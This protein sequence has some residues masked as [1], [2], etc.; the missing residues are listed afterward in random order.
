[1]FAHAA[2]DDFWQERLHYLLYYDEAFDDAEEFFTETEQKRIIRAIA[3]IKVIDPAVGS[4][5]F[6]MGILHKLTLA[7]RRLDADNH[8]WEDLQKELAGQRATAAFDTA[9]QQVRDEELREI[10]DTFQK[11]R[12]SDF[13]RKLY[14][15]QNSIFGVDI[16]PIACQIAKLRF[17]ISLAIEQEPDDTAT[18]YGIKPLPNLET[19]FVAANTLL[20]LGG[21]NRELISARTGELQRRLN[22]NRERHFHATTRRQKLDCREKDQELRDDLAAQLK[23]DGLPAAAANKVARWDPYDQNDKADW[24]DAEYM[25]GLTAGFDVVI[26]NPPY[27]ESRNSLLSGE[28]KDAYGNQVT[29]DWGEG[30]PRGSDLLIYFYAR[31]A[32]LV[33]DSGYGCFITQNAWLDTNYGHKFQKFSIGKF[34]F[35][36]IVDTSAKFFSDIS[37]QNINAVITI[38][39][40]RKLREIEYGIADEDMKLTSRRSIVARQKM[41]WGHAFQM[42]LFLADI[43]SRLSATEGTGGVIS[44][45]QGLN[46]PLRELDQHGSKVPV[47]VR[48]AQFL[49][50][51]ADGRIRNVSA[52][53]KSRIP[54]LIMPRGV[55]ERHYCTFN[56]CKAFSYSRVEVYIPDELWWSGAHYCLWAYLNSSFVWLYREITGRKNLG[57]GMLKAEATDMKT[58]PVDFEFDFAEDAKRVLETIRGREPKPVSEEVQTKEH[59]LID[60]MVAR[61]FGFLTMQESIRDALIE[62]VNFRSAR[63]RPQ[64]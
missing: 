40:K 62:H 31:S 23:Q 4:G 34:S 45:G 17:F 3:N 56:V 9:N 41:K 15:I 8:R 36:R 30:L 39:T 48:D 37:S 22:E 63:A 27:V 12:E 51:N 59:L 47:I 58:L 64:E 20:A 13:G 1:M 26:G 32:K 46:F 44:F 7:L 19:R 11:Y 43:L 28:M 50:A 53:R 25:F 29:A 33:S 60:D 24:F 21:L 57:G 61:Y 10:S 5:A 6:P 42:P 54:A 16:Q 18:N 38:F 49:A 14:L 52:G 35:H 55:G 2:D